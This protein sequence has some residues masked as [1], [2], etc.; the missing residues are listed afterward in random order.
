MEV[1]DLVKMRLSLF[2]I[3]VLLVIG[4]IMLICLFSVF[5]LDYNWLIGLALGSL[6]SGASPLVVDGWTQRI[7]DDVNKE[8]FPI[9][10]KIN[11]TKFS[12]LFDRF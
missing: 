1:K 7:T 8:S 9:L 4:E 5:I 3:V 6:L 11:H 10:L 12:K 2:S